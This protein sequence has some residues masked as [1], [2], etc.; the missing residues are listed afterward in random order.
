MTLV[1]ESRMLKGML[2]DMKVQTGTYKDDQQQLIE[3]LRLQLNET[4]EM[5][6]KMRE[7]KEKEFRK[8]KE[9]YEDER[10]R[11]NEQYQLEFEKLKNE[12]MLNQRKLG[13]EEHYNKEL[14]ILNNKLQN[15]ITNVRGGDNDIRK[16]IN[17]KETK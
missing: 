16:S 6:N 12:V 14:A 9:K 3:N 1:Q 11:E 8:I 2:D 4:R 15:N 13:Q 10:R 17:T 7:N 5:I